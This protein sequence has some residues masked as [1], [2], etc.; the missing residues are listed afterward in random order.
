MM[1]HHIPFLFGAAFL[2]CHA[3]VT[4]QDNNSTYD[5]YNWTEVDDE[6][7]Y[8]KLFYAK[9]ATPI[10][11]SF[12]VAFNRTRVEDLNGTVSR[13]AKNGI[14]VDK[15]LTGMKMVK[16]TV[17]A[18]D[19]GVDEDAAKEERKAKLLVWLKNSL[20]DWIEEV[21]VLEISF[22]T[23]DASRYGRMLALTIMHS[24]L[25]LT[26]TGRTK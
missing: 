11:N 26:Y 20:V 18:T 5:S 16:I 1:K 8:A 19:S 10:K 14:V 6:S 15:Y 3:A 23:P 25:P 7:A 17:N 9:N 24:L 21:R 22:R 13:L 4:A 2:A 12:V